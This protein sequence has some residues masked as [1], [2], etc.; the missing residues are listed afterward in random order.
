MPAPFRTFRSRSAWLAAL[1]FV[2]AASM[3]LAPSAD[4]DIW[5]HLAAGREM[6][7][8][9]HLLFSDP[10]SVGASGRPWADVHWLFQLT[11]YAVHSA[12]GLAGLVWAKCLVVAGSALLL[13]AIL[14]HKK[15]SWARPLFVTLLLA[16]LFAARSLLLV[17]PVIVS[18]FFLA[19]FLYEL[20]GYRRDGRVR[21][22]IVLPIAQVLWANFQGLSALG[23]GVVGAYA[24]A[25]GLSVALSSKRAWVF[26]PEAARG[27]AAGRQFRAQAL[28]L[29]ACCVALALTPFGLLGLSLPAKLLGRL[30]PGEHN[31]YA[32]SVAENV[33]PFLLERW[34]HGEFW[35]LKWF[36]GLL[37]LAM[38]CGGRRLRLSHVLLVLGFTALALMSNRNVLLLYWVASPLA[39]G[40][41]APVARARVLRWNRRTGQRVALVANALAI[42]ALFCGS[43]V[44]AAHE[45]ALDQPSPFRVPAE[46]AQRL[47]S[48]PQSGDIFSADHHGGYLIWQLYPR[49]RP[50]IDTRLV[51]RSAREFAEYLQL[52]DEPERF[53]AFQGKY[54]FGYVVLPVDYPDRYLS[55]IA[56]L[57]ASP[58]W[59]L[60]FTNGSEVLFA[61]RDIPTEPAWDL[62]AS[63]V[64]ERVLRGTERQFADSPKSLAAARLHLAMLDIAVGEI[65][66][67]ER[68][69]SVVALPEAEALR[70]RCRIAAGDI[71]GA[72]RI[73]ERLLR[74][75]K[76]DV[77]S[78]NL[79][80]QIA[81]RRGQPA[82]GVHFLRRALQSDPFD[83]EAS[84]LLANLEEN[85]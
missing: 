45:S 41:L 27:L 22:L 48:L 8:R 66:Q 63:E 43:S 80:A 74:Q 21:H 42:A 5:W 17:R 68:V 9:G 19:L 15:G 64:T 65:A 53:D 20:E 46:S 34:S 29:G 40:Y 52:A 39:A 2:G 78:L 59:K 77:S 44:A 10:F 47:A 37:A 81:L 11:T 69:L 24:A 33:P 18:L 58:D 67:A 26:A 79:M 76:D 85:R 16:A 73:G 70:A 72:Q 6:V 36:L 14:E 57:Y 62:S 38:A 71:A 75:D 60:L 7:A 50:Y 82:E 30:I 28:A 83:G 1:L 3:G 25:A 12:F 32:H 61:R 35:H 49:F 55:L 54:H 31:V 51:L 4:G 23:P 84:Q 13:F 56:H